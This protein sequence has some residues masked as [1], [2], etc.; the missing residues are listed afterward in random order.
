MQRS[1]LA[2]DGTAS[3]ATAHADQQ[4][5]GNSSDGPTRDAAAEDTAFDSP[6][7]DE[8]N[9]ADDS[10]NASGATPVPGSEAE[11]A[12]A[13]PSP[14]PSDEP[15]G[16]PSGSPAAGSGTGEPAGTLK[17]SPRPRPTP[18]PGT[19]GTDAAA[20]EP[21]AGTDAGTP[22]T[23]AA[24]QSAEKPTEPAAEQSA[25]KPAEQSVEK[26][27]DATAPPRVKP[28]PRPRS[29][30]APS[31]E[32]RAPD[33]GPAPGSVAHAPPDGDAPPDTD[34]TP[35]ADASTAATGTQG[36]EKV[37]GS[38]AFKPSPRPRS[39]AATT[40]ATAVDA[41]PAKD[42]PAEATEGDRAAAS[43]ETAGAGI[44]S[45]PA[46][47]DQST[48]PGD[49]PG[50]GHLAEV[51]DPP[52]T[53]TAEAPVKD[54]DAGART[55]KRWL[56]RIGVAA[57]TVALML[58]IPAFVV[59]MYGIP[60]E[61]METTLHGCAGCD[62]DRVLVDRTVYRFRTPHPGE[63]VVFTAGPE[64]WGNS[65]EQMPGEA[66]PLVRGLQSM[67][68]MVGIAPPS[69]P[70][71]VKRV[72]AVGGQTVSCCDSRNRIIVDGVPVDEPYVY[73]SLA[74][75]PAKQAPFP[76]VRVPDG[77]MW[78]MGDN[79]NASLDSRAPGNG[80]VPVT[81]LAGKVRMIIYPLSRIGTV[82]DTNPQQ[83]R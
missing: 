69:G 59:R 2:G 70:D 74:A 12:S 76:K 61:S 35:V 6:I 63:V 26:A 52:G 16:E 43:V 44:D 11:A 8:T 45:A 56:R 39:V 1:E 83:P 81:A 7:R 19:S 78:M 37:G 27:G 10:E 71:F 9:D 58:F 33:A 49:S 34:A 65:E 22:P 4:A 31:A 82:D 54:P 3:E 23:P 55:R 21:G 20:P 36:P 41:T 80:P 67:G 72:I 18:G 5:T 30:P 62:N 15:T 25:D 17:P 64:I 13:E 48:G 66:N 29:T 28:S 50:W 51:D 73:Y 77:M 46:E 42:Q 57:A 24:E 40:P 38:G 32:G 53:D 75:G 47:P 79:R 68:E 60:S 14:D